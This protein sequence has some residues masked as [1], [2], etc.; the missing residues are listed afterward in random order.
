M[1]SRVRLLRTGEFAWSCLTNERQ[2]RVLASTSR[3]LWLMT[4]GGRLFWLA[5][6]EA[7]MHRRC[8]W[9]DEGVPQMAMDTP[10]AVH[11]DELVMGPRHA[12]GLGRPDVWHAPL[13]GRAAPG[14]VIGSGVRGL[15]SVLGA[16]EQSGFALLLPRIL[17]TVEAAVAPPGAEIRNAMLKRAE[18]L[19]L[20]IVQAGIAG[21]L[22][23]MMSMAD[24]LV[25]LG[26]GLTPSGDDFLGGLLFAIRALEKALPPVKSR[27]SVISI[28][29]Y[30]GRTHLISLTLL[31][32]L[33]KGHAI[34]PMHELVNG[35]ISG[36]SRDDFHCHTMDLIRVGHSTGWDLLTGLLTGL[37]IGIRSQ[38][39]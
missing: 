16:V 37:L 22:G 38:E 26:S 2:G 33:A 11:D 32:D 15:I 25:G 29:R 4:S 12:I 5:D 19:V 31:D 6:A 34:A 21:Q 9:L 1:G 39:G 27:S 7:P 17:S 35:L 30:A 36:E 20:G 14:E 24:G 8:G 10:Y 3:T 28:E 18:P 13:P 23:E